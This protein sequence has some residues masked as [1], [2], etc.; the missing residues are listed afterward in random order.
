MKRIDLRSDTVTLPTDEMRKAM[1]NAEV[2]DDVYM[3]DPTVNLL[4]KKA[5][6]LE[7]RIKSNEFTLQDFYD[8]MVQLKSMGSMQDILAQMPGGAS[9][10]NIQLDEEYPSYYV[11]VEM[12][13]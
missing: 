4:Q 8:Q 11:D 5:A 12:T 3:D 9:L 7:D 2:G 1:A 10:K 6:E 13:C